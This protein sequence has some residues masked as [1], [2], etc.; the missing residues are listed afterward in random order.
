MKRIAILCICLAFI[1]SCGDSANSSKKELNLPEIKKDSTKLIALA[2]MVGEG[3]LLFKQYCFPCHAMP[4][5]EHQCGSSLETVFDRLPQPADEYCLKFILDSERLRNDG[6]A[7]ARQIGIDYNSNFE[8]TFKDSLSISQVQNIIN[9]L[10]YA[11]ELKDV[12]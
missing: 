12:N 6:D 11:N 5:E 7:Y 8:H 9:Y 10:K 2:D 3:K 1:Y 4:D